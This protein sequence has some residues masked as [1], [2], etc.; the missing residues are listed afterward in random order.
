MKNKLNEIL[1]ALLLSASRPIN[2]DEMVKVF[3]D[4]KPSKDDIRSALNQ[5]DE[6]CIERGI[7]LKQVASGYRLQV[8][9]NLSAYV[10]KLWEERPQKFSKATLETLSLIAYKQ[11]ITRG[12]IEEIRGVTVGTQLMRGLMERGWVKIIGQRDVPGR[13]SLY[14]TTKEFLDYFG[15]Q[16]L[17]ELPEL[18]SLP[19]LNS[20][21]LQ[22]PIEEPESKDNPQA[23]S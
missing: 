3:D 16:H 10:A 20:L 17:R 2:I 13:P 21:E 12:E 9:Q 11:P 18:P 4:P 1:E 6:D 14:A 22:L 15:L 19:D 5:L 8:K 23:L 7:E